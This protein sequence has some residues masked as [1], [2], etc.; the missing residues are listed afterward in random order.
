MIAIIIV[1]TILLIGIG[2]YLTYNYTD[3]DPE[4]LHVLGVTGTFVGGICTLMYVI[5]IITENFCA[6]SKIADAKIEYE[7]LCKRRDIIQSEYEDVSKTD[8]VKDI[9]EWNIKVQNAKYWGKH[10]LTNWFYSQK[11]VD[12]LEYIDISEI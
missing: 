4:C 5:V 2:A 7:S 11:Y 1:V 6:D 12:S 3:F 8:V 9:A 10:P